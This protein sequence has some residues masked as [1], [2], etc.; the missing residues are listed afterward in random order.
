MSK[1][2]IDRLLRVATGTILIAVVIA[3]LKA[4]TLW[5]QLSS[6]RSAALE[7]WAAHPLELAAA[8]S[9]GLVVIPRV[10]RLFIG[11]EPWLA[12]RSGMKIRIITLALAASALGTANMVT[13]H[14]LN[15]EPRLTSRLN[16]EFAKVPKAGPT[17]VDMTYAS[18]YAVRGHT[19]SALSVEELCSRLKGG[20]TRTYVDSSCNVY[21][22][23]NGAVVSLTV[24]GSTDL[25][26]IG[27]GGTKISIEIEADYPHGF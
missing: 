10:I 5:F 13:D 6:D 2:T 23:V 18:D 20:P 3:S 21:Y 1:R 22:E 8:V 7:S 12:N 24:Y 26:S 11:N 9:F 15:T 27:G 25:R 19:S 14:R 4:F 17:S 16:A